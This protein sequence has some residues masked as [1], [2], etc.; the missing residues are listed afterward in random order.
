M[1]AGYDIPDAATIFPPIFQGGANLYDGTS[2]LAKLNDPKVNQL[3]D[4]ALAK[5]TSAEALP[6]WQELNKY[7]VEQSFVIPRFVYKVAPIMGS[8]VKGAYISPV[9][10]NVD[11]TNAYISKT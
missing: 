2:N 7:I 11:V 1:A 3:I 9:L 4:Q 6:I 8:K 10:G 5:P